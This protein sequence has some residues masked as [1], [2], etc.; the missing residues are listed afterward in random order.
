MNPELV[1]VVGDMF[2]L[3]D[4][5]TSPISSNQFSSQTSSSTSYP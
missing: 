5:P 2:V 4:H 3:R 1:L